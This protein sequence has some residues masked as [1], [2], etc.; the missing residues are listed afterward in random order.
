MDKNKEVLKKYTELW[1]GIK[2]EIETINGGK[3]GENGKDFRKIKL[4]IDDNLSLNKPLK[5]HLLI[6][7][8]RCIF[9]EDKAS[10]S[11][12]HDVLMTTYKFKNIAILNVKGVDFR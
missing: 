3:K 5:L 9:E 2:N 4:T 10:A 1:N 8:L 6:I 7:T 11:K 12:C